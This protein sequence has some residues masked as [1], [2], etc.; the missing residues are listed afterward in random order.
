MSAF[1][2]L[3]NIYNNFYTTQIY[4]PFGGI[5]VPPTISDMMI[6]INKSIDSEFTL[7]L[8]IANTLTN[9]ANA[10]FYISATNG[11]TYMTTATNQMINFLQYW[12]VDFGNDMWSFW[13]VG[14]A[15]WVYAWSGYWSNFGVIILILATFGYIN[16]ALHRFVFN[17]NHSES[18]LGPKIALSIGVMFILAYG[19]VVIITMAGQASIATFCTVLA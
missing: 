11:V 16:G 15:R 13:N 17:A 3:Q 1:G 10:M 5:G 12:I 8:N 7:L 19:C 4:M 9:S 6:T 2:Q 14:Y 18:L